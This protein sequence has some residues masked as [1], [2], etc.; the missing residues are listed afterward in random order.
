MSGIGN[1]NHDDA[2]FNDYTLFI[3]HSDL[4][5]PLGTDDTFTF[6]ITVKEYETEDLLARKNN[7]S[8]NYKSN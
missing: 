1:V 2:V 7:E 5:L 8:F 3:K 6:D 4:N